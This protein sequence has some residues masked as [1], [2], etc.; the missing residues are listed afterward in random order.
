MEKRYD[1]IKVGEHYCIVDSLYAA[2]TGEKIICSKTGLIASKATLF[3]HLDDHW[4]KLI[5]ISNQEHY[6]EEI[7]RFDI[8][9]LKSKIDWNKQTFNYTDIL[10]GISAGL[11]IGYSPAFNMDNREQEIDGILNIIL[12]N[13]E[14]IACDLE[15]EELEAVDRHYQHSTSYERFPLITNNQVSITNVYFQ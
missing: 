12:M 9:Q 3:A 10:K 14:P 13:K 5:A 7:P 6:D 1:L 2:M 15:C 11:S 4:Y 8:T